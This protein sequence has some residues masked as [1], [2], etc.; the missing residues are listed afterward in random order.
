[1]IRKGDRCFTKHSGSIDCLTSVGG[2]FNHEAHY[3]T[4]RR[5]RFEVGE[6]VVE[7]TNNRTGVVKRTEE[8]RYK[9]LYEVEM[10][11]TKG[12]IVFSPNQLAPYI[13]ETK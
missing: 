13:E 10:Q 6:K 11:D 8:F 2:K 1:M 4:I 9:V 7:L 12:V 5:N 3:P